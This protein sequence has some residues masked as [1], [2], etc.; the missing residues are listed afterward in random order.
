MKRTP[1]GE[2]GY[3]IGALFD[4]MKRLEVMVEEASDTGSDDARALAI[5][6][7]ANNRADGGC[8]ELAKA[9]RQTGEADQAVV[10]FLISR[11]VECAFSERIEKDPE[12]MKINRQIDH[13]RQADGLN[14]DEFWPAGEAPDDIE[15]LQAA[16][17]GRMYEMKIAILREWGEVEM[18]DLLS[19]DRDAFA[20]R[21]E[22]GRKK[23]FGPLPPDLRSP[24][25]T[26]TLGDEDDA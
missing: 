16:W 2:R 13:R 4:L 23:F 25:T 24:R 5:A 1:P 21:E 11:S 17:D 15:E 22:E 18:A 7:L 8:L 12:L 3:D 10:F 20:R 19:C 6:A 26:A 14:E 9:L